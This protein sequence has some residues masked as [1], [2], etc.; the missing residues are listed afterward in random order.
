[1]TLTWHEIIHRMRVPVILTHVFVC[2]CAPPE[3]RSKV[4]DLKQPR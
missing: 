4:F 2:V 1:M 3:F